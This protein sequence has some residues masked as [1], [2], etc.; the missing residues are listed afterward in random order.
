[1]SKS[2]GIVNCHAAGEVGDVIVSGVD[3]PPG[4]TIWEQ[5]RF[6]AADQKLR[7]LVLNEPRGCVAKHVNLLVPA[8]HPDADYGFIIL[9]PE[10]T[11]PMSGSNCICV[12]TVL[13]ERGLVP[14]QGPQANLVL[15][16]PGGLVSVQADIENGKVMAV[17]LE[18]LPSFVDR[19]QVPLSVPGVGDLTVDTAFGG[20]SFVLV[21]VAQVGCEIKPENARELAELGIRITTAANEQLGFRHPVLRDWKHIS[22]CCLAE[23]P[24]RVQNQWIG[25]H[26]VAIRPGKLDRCPTGTGCSARLAQLHHSGLIKEGEVFVGQSLI[27]SKF[28]C[29]IMGTTK[30][31][32]TGSSERTAVIPRISGSAWITGTQEIYQ[33]ND[34]PFAEGYRLSD[35]WPDFRFTD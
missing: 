14:Y 23:P 7:N 11:P 21:D 5:S 12:A 9:E 24:V 19:Y 10:D 3:P 13:L 8:I 16:A 28:N 31:G 4:K 6:L 27:G 17:H 34:D 22:F 32:S 33:L 29:R 15:E 1:M 26:A 25:K 20:D 18:N 2:I 35:T 30:I